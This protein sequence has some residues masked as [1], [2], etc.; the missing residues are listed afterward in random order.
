M[1]FA[2]TGMVAV[3]AVV[4]VVICALLLRRAFRRQSEAEKGVAY[5]N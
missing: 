2:G 1:F 5:V 3:I 4:F